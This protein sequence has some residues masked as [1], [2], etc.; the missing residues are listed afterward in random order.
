MQEAAEDYINVLLNKDENEIRKIIEG[1]DW[2]IDTSSQDQS[3]A[4]RILKKRASEY[5]QN[6]VSYVSLNCL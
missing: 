5:Y 4:I 2:S 1:S 3:E 6:R